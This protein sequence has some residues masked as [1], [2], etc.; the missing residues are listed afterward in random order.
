MISAERRYQANSR[1][2]TTT[3]QVI[4]EALNLER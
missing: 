1:I 4:Q 3:D 2:I